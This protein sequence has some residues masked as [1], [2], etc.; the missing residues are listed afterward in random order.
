MV[1][2]QK[3]IDS[4]VIN[5]LPVKQGVIYIYDYPIAIC[6]DPQ[7]ASILTRYDSVFHIE[8]G[9]V[10]AVYNYG[11]DREKDYLVIIRNKKGQF[12]CYSNLDSAFVKKRDVVKK[13]TVIGISGINAERNCRQVDFMLFNK[14]QKLTFAKEIEYLRFTSCKVPAGYTL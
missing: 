10:V 11:L 4:L 9:E 13:G 7:T 2:A 3:I 1:F 8:E 6:G 14:A 12:I 5:E